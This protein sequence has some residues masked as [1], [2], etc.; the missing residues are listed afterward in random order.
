MVSMKFFHTISR[1][2]TDACATLSR[3]KVVDALQEIAQAHCEADSDAQAILQCIT[4]IVEPGRAVV[5]AAAAPAPT[6][7]ASHNGASIFG[8]RPVVK[9]PETFHGPPPAD[10]FRNMAVIPSCNDVLSKEDSVY[11]PLTLDSHIKQN[12]VEAHLDRHFRWYHESMVAPFRQTVQAFLL[13]QFSVSKS[14]NFFRPPDADP[15]IVTSSISVCGVHFDEREGVLFNIESDSPKE[16][17][18]NADFWLKGKGSDLYE[19]QKLVC[20]CLNLSNI[21]ASLKLHRSDIS[22]AHERDV[23]FLQIVDVHDNRSAND[24]WKCECGFAVFS[25]R[26]ACPQCGAPRP[27]E[28]AKP[29]PSKSL[30]QT[31]CHATVRFVEG[32]PQRF[33]LRVKCLS[34]KDFDSM[35]ALSC[36]HFASFG[37]QPLNH[38]ENVMLYFPRNFLASYTPILKSLQNAAI[39]HFPMISN[40]V[41]AMQMLEAP[42]YQRVHP[43]SF[44]LSCVLVKDTASDALWA[45]SIRPATT[46]AIKTAL[47]AHRDEIC[48]DEA[49]MRAFVGALTRRIS[50]VQGPPGVSYSAVTACK[51]LTLFSADW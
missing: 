48:F 18:G 21:K 3:L 46:T 17:K 41:D 35:I 9:A 14:P 11:L 26:S 39:P 20:L 15:A 29:K 28:H 42:P 2:V 4:C 44:D 12:P 1:Y 36:G 24:D 7:A 19:S 45:R 49:Q 37:N 30:A 22:L 31:P 5:P 34:R 51:H 8:R 16:C 47:E 6:I 40:L 27:S 32:S 50:L 25:S 10:H 23:I 43:F 33:Q 13:S 38:I